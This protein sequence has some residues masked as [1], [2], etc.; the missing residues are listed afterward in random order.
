MNA[1]LIAPTLPTISV[2]VPTY[3]AA[4][5]IEEALNSVLAQTL[6]PTEIIVIDDGSTDETREVVA[7][8]GS[9]KIN[10]VQQENSGVSSAR[11]RGLELAAGEFV[12]FLDADDIW[13]DDMLDLQYKLFDFDAS[14][15]C[16]IANFVR[17]D[18]ST[19]KIM[20]EQ[21]SFYPELQSLP[22]SS[23]PMR[24]TNIL[25]DDPFT[26]LVMF[27]DI[28]AFTQ[29]M[30]FRRKLIEGLRFNEKLRICEDM[31]FVMR[32]F[33]RGAVAFNVAV[34]A[35]I[36]RHDTNATINY[37]HIA[38][39][40]LEALR[41]FRTDDLN[42][43][44]MLA[45]SSRLIRAHIDAGQVLARRGDFVSGISLLFQGARIRGEYKR[46]CKGFL[47]ILQEGLMSLLGSRA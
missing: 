46:K 40:K 32:A 24:G 36:R 7:S 29:T 10:Y 15:V 9:E 27:S 18:S 22:L 13:H 11:N 23:G 17:F 3:N 37:E 43:R 31:E 2:I 8:L 25:A 4:R 28:P 26:K 41:R 45:Y 38:L 33:L 19:G 42:E 1:E 34:L 16:S 47:R 5:F 39:H 6:Q 20:P 35:K 21:F 12:A 30:M 14:L 44:Q